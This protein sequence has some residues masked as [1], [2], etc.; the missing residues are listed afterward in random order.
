MTY[1]YV[2]RYGLVEFGS[3]I[4]EG[5]IKLL[6]G[7]GKKFIDSIKVK[8]QLAH[9]NKSWLLPGVLEATTEDE[10]IDALLEFVRWHKFTEQRKQ[11]KK[12]MMQ[13]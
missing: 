3:R 7:K 11:F 4:P 10:A 1:A 5:A 8:C 6:E 2:W 12:R 13:S 9:D